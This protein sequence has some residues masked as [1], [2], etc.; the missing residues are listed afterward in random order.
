[1]AT[2]YPHS[3]VFETPS[4]RRMERDFR[5]L[6]ALLRNTGRAGNRLEIARLANNTL[7]LDQ[8]ADAIEHSHTLYYGAL[9]AADRLLVLLS[10]HPDMR[11]KMVRSGE[12][13]CALLRACLRR[14]GPPGTQTQ[15]WLLR[16]C[17]I[18]AFST[19][20]KTHGKQLCIIMLREWGAIRFDRSFTCLDFE[21]EFLARDHDLHFLRN[22]A[23]ATL[24]SPPALLCCQRLGALFKYIDPIRR[25]TLAP[26]DCGI[27]LQPCCEHTQAHETASKLQ[28][29]IFRRRALEV[30]IALQ[31][32]SLPVL[33]TLGIVDELLPNDY[34]MFYKWELLKAVKHFH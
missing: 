20:Y 18:G 8:I 7:A 34:T 4:V 32:L 14:R 1:M 25:E 17:I 5:A 22:G 29:L 23:L 2:V 10:N 19:F 6:V 21:A 28:R 16:M 13:I 33:L 31:Y 11:E 3:N 9:W 30:A 12:K 24:L 27:D 15:F 26:L